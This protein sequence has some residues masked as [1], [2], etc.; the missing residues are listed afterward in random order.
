MTRAETAQ[1]FFNL[2]LEKNIEISQTFPDLPEGAWFR[3]AVETL[4]SLGVFAWPSDGEFHPSDP[5]TRAEFVSI[6]VRFTHEVLGARHVTEFTDVPESHW[7]HNDIVTAASYGWIHGYGDG[8]FQPDRQ[9]S[10][11]EVVVLTN[12]L[13]GRV[14]DREYIGDHTGLRFFGDVPTTH[15][16]FYDIAEASNVHHYAGHVQDDGEDWED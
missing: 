10:R 5:I 7:A 14:P 6:A 12:R 9:I 15:W 11:A 3:T 16:A 2:L 8:R 1:M 13:L 4:A